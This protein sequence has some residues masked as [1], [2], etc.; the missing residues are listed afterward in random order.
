MFIVD[1]EIA[2]KDCIPCENLFYKD[3][4]PRA[5]KPLLGSR[6]KCTRLRPRSSRLLGNLSSSTGPSSAPVDTKSSYLRGGYAIATTPL[7][8]RVDTYQHLEELGAITGFCCS[9]RVPPTKLTALE[10]PPQHLIGKFLLRRR[11]L[12]H[13]LEEVTAAH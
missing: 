7:K 4:K 13:P 10:K 5:D 6:S 9:Q 2:D 1:V 11:H 8:T 3:V 12:V